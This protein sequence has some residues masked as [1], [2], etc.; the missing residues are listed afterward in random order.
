MEKTIAERLDPRRTLYQVMRDLAGTVPERPAL[1]Y[2]K[3][4]ITFAALKR[5][6]N[7]FAAALTGFGV[8]KDDVVT[9]CLP[10]I[11]DAVYLLYAI[12]QL[13]AVGSIVHPLYSLTQ[14]R[15]SVRL[16]GSRLAFVLDLNYQSFLP[17]E[18]DGVRLIA[19]SPAAE[20]PPLMRLIYRH[21]N[22]KKIGK[23]ET[24]RTTAPFR[25]CAPLTTCDDDYRKDAI[26]LNSGGTTG[27]AKTIAISARAINALA[28]NGG[29]I[30][31]IRDAKDV[32]ML[33]VL[34]MFHGFGLAMGIH[35]AL[36][37]GGHDVLMPKFSARATA[38]YIRRGEITCLIGIPIL[39]QALLDEPRFKGKALRVLGPAFVGGDFVSPALT[40][41]Y[42]ERMKKAGARSRLR[43]GY[44]LT[45]TVTVCTVNTEV[46]HKTGTVGRPLPNVRLKVVDPK[47]GEDLGRNKE[48]ELLVGGATLM[49]GY[50]YCPKE[51]NDDVFVTD[52]RGDLFVRSGDLCLIDEDGYLVFRQRLKRIIKVNGIPV[53]PSDV[54]RAATAL[55]F[56]KECAAVGMSDE[57]RGHMVRLFVVLDKEAPEDE[58]KAR[59]LL[60]A[61]I[62]DKCGIYARPKEIVFLETLPHTMLGKVDAKK[63]L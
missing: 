37:F 20:L 43:E 13:G 14:L 49:N 41:R 46:F 34:P 10:N 38:D 59:E 27:K 60:F 3:R 5:R 18:Q 31:G 45:E 62:V 22:R 39:Y 35:V 15:E 55:S 4:K 63:L 25:K 9:V 7:Q 8:K 29:Y 26:L 42:D 56:V 47:T 40:E 51:Y 2:R 1:I 50:R 54:E 30:L 33:S 23:I 53:Y 58:E 28:A 32:G 21:E 57:K 12:N 61:A 16:T 52:E 6:I 36:C 44:G 17:L 48:G 19:V 11:P 24:S